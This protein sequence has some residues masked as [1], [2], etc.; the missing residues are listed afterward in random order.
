[1]LKSVPV[2]TVDGPSGVGKGTVSQHL[3]KALAWHYLDSGALYRIAAYAA[4]QASV[5]LDSPALLVELIDRVTIEFNEGA[6]LN[7]VC[8]ESDIRTELAGDRA[9]IV[10]KHPAVRHAMLN[11]QHSFLS[12]PGLVADGRDMGTTI[13]PQAAHKFYLTADP[14]ARAKR[15]AIQLKA[16]GLDGNIGALFR[17]IK[18]RDERDMNRADSPLVPAADAIIIDTTELGIDEVL[19]KVMSLLPY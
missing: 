2:I 8:I 9:S 7:G 11:L 5:D 13:F 12:E 1:M 16:A 18:Q 19:K 6:Y 17:D 10:A 15:R 3:A 4:I 14:E